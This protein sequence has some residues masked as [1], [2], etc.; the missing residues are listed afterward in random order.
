MSYMGF[1]EKQGIRYFQ[2]DIFREQPFFHALLTRHGGYSSSPFDSLNTGGTVG[3]NPLDVLKNHQKIFQVFS[4]D[5]RSRFDVWQVHGTNI[6]CTESPRSPGTPH[7]KAD[8]IL[9]NKHNVTLFM[10]FADCVPVLIYDPQNH[11]I[12]IIHA[13]W[14]GT[15]HRIVKAAVEKMANCYHSVPDSLVVGIGPAICVDCY[16]VGNDVFRA[17]RKNFGDDAA[18]FFRTNQGK[19]HLDLCAA[20]IDIL[21]RAG[22][23]KIENA[24]ICTS[25]Q[26]E[27][28]YSHRG[29]NGRTGRYGVLM[30]LNQPDQDFRDI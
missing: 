27:D 11:V 29:Q 12:G 24:N 13:G 1:K 7:E 20:N 14:Q 15:V 22:V 17:F 25:C 4:F 8:G 19:R 10:R 5:Y 6:I 3:D 18:R 28:W 16:E 21:R 2:F 30:S 23:K 9:T 26:P